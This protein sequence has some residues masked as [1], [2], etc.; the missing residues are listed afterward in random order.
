MSNPYEPPQSESQK[1][2]SNEARDGST[3]SFGLVEIVVIVAIIIVMVGLLLPA[4]QRA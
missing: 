3:F 4:W 1:D 2:R